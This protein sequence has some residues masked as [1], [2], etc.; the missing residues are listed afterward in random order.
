MMNDDVWFH[1][2]V[3][4]LP[5]DLWNLIR[6]YEI[7][8]VVNIAYLYFQFLIMKTSAIFNCLPRLLNIV[9]IASLFREASNDTPANLATRCKPPSCTRRQRGVTTSRCIKADR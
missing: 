5:I 7:S 1:I 2:F 6:L 9:S 8:D 3:E 4:L